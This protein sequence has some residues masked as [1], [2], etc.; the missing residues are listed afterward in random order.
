VRA[1]L[2]VSVSAATSG[3]ER[4]FAPRA[5]A[6]EPA[7]SVPTM[8]V[9]DVLDVVSLLT[10]TRFRS[11]PQST[12]LIGGIRSGTPPALMYERRIVGVELPDQSIVRLDVWTRPPMGPVI[13]VRQWSGLRGVRLYQENPGKRVSESRFVVGRRGYVGPEVWLDDARVATRLSQLAE[14]VTALPCAAENPPAL[15]TAGRI[16]GGDKPKT[17][18]YAWIMEWPPRPGRR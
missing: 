5:N 6:V 7:A 17:G 3:C 4:V 18:M 13:F 10:E 1:A 15:N 12:C 9:M 8:P 11:N 14:L 16:P 2:A